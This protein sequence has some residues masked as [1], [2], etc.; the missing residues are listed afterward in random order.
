[1]SRIFNMFT[2]PSQQP[3]YSANEAFN[4]VVNGNI[5]SLSLF[6]GNFNIFKDYSGNNLLH[7]AVSTENIDIIKLLLYNGV[8]MYFKNKQRRSP[9][10]L[11]LRS[12]NKN[13]LQLFSTYD[14]PYKDSYGTLLIENGKL[15]DRNKT[16]E[17]SNKKITLQNDTLT[18]ET[19]V[20]RKNNKR[21]RED[22]D[23]YRFKVNS[24]VTENEELRSENKKLKISL[25][26]LSDAFKK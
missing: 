16:L 10:D 18:E 17:E 15:N 21:L 9:W 11:A 24:F 1:M 23:S 14:N 26:N 20:L 4:D 25:D 6:K 13:M 3:V 22:N 12:Q 7:V 8:D 2:N 19:N 5:T